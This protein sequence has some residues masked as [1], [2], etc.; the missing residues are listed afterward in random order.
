MQFLFQPPKSKTLLSMM[1]LL[2]H[3][4]QRTKIHIA[5]RLRNRKLSTRMNMLD[6]FLH[7][8]FTSFVHSLFFS[9]LFPFQFKLFF[10]FLFFLSIL[11]CFFSSFQ[12]K[13]GWTEAALMA[14]AKDVGLSPSIV[15]SLSRKE[16][17]LVEVHFLLYLTCNAMQVIIFIGKTKS[18]ID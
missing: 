11:R 12:M 16:A 14:G 1:P 5:S 18:H 3:Q 8:S 7:H 13:L 15:G 10:S 9:S 2:L 6:C 17:A 4:H